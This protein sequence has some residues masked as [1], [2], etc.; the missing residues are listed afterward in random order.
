MPKEYEIVFCD[1]ASYR[2]RLDVSTLIQSPRE[3]AIVQL[4]SLGICS[5]QRTKGVRVWST[6]LP[7]IQQTKTP[8]RLQV[9]LS[10]LGEQEKGKHIKIRIGQG[11]HSSVERD[12]TKNPSHNS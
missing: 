11:S 5:Y 10:F 12:Y 3:L 8:A 9:G 2:Y 7:R 1:E 4:R 6:S